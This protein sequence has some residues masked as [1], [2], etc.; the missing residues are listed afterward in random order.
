MKINFFSNKASAIIKK[1]KN[2]YYQKLFKNYFDNAKKTWELIKKLTSNTNKCLPI[3]KLIYSATVFSD[4]DGIAYAFN[5]FFANS[6]Q[7][8]NVDL[9][10][11][12]CDPLNSVMRNPSSIFLTSITERECSEI[13]RNL[14]I[15]G[16]VREKL[17][18]YLLIKFKTYLV[19][20][21]CEI[22]NNCLTQGEFPGPLESATVI[23]KLKS[24]DHSQSANYRPFSLLPIFSEVIE[25]FIHSSF[26]YFLT[27][28]F[29]ISPTQ[30]G[31]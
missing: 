24:G 6:E 30:I 16:Q 7:S 21:H 26:N 14:K 29:I 13:V 3:R 15:T 5:E 20:I 23:P 4:D 11:I 1:N 9:E 18:V 31:F 27:K 2:A 25:R 22:I 12:N 28:H 17:P 19:P 10:T 8:L